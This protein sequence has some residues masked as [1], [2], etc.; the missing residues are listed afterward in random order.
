MILESPSLFFSKGDYLNILSSPSIEAAAGYLAGKFIAT[1]VG[2]V[3][4]ARGVSLRD[5]YTAIDR[6][7]GNAIGKLVSEMEARER[8]IAEKALWVLLT[9]D[10]YYSLKAL[11]A[12]LE[13]PLMV[14]PL[15]IQL[16]E[17]LRFGDSKTIRKNMPRELTSFVTEYLEKKSVSLPGLVKAMDEL[18][19]S[20]SKYE[21]YESRVVAGLL[22]DLLLIK[23]CYSNP[24]VKQLQPRAF[25]LNSG[26]LVEMCGKSI[27]DSVSLLAKTRPVMALFSSIL[28]D[29]LRFSSG[30]EALD[31]AIYT[32][33]QYFASLLL[34]KPGPER[35]F[36]LVLKL[37]GQNVLLKF[38]F[39][40][41]HSGLYRQE[42]TQFMSKWVV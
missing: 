16:L 6:G 38:A 14:S 36:R 40:V 32:S 27:V 23:L 18:V 15:P 13:P 2:R 37:L 12:G 28:S 24:E 9:P 1:D 34:L 11:S 17:A 25:S 22:H 39:T 42:A 4:E 30:I 7:Y 10:L 33:S 19:N 29:A 20:I 26:E 8:L 31:L 21:Y 35:A 41:V 5:I 3:F